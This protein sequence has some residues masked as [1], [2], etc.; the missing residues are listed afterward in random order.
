MVLEASSSSSVEIFSKDRNFVRRSAGV[1]DGSSVVV[2]VA[3]DC[4]L[5]RSLVSF[6]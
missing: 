3:E 6:D 1:C 5:G 2:V 4:E